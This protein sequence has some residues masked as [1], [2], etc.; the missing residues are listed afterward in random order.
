M[1]DGTFELCPQCAAPCPKHQGYPIWCEACGWSVEPLRPRPPASLVEAARARAGT[2]L[3]ASV[4][5]EVSGRRT[6]GIYRAATYLYA[7]LSYAILAAC[8]FGGIALIVLTWVNVFLIVIGVVLIGIAWVAR[9]RP[10][11]APRLVDRSAFAEVHALAD[12]VAEA[13][14]A[15]RVDGIAI[16]G[17]F[18]ASFGRYGWRGRRI[19]T[20]GLPLLTA[21]DPQERVALVAHEIAHDVNRD[22]ARTLFVANAFNVL[23]ELHDFFL[24]QQ[25]GMGLAY[26]RV[27]TRSTAMV[28]VGGRIANIVLGAVGL[29]IRPFLRLFALLMQRDSQRAEYLAD[30]LAA[31]VAGDASARTMLR[32]SHLARTFD[33]LAKG[34]AAQ[35][36]HADILAALRRWVAD[37]PDSEWRRVERIMQLE[38]TQI[39]STHP[40]S[41]QRI[42]FLAGRAPT[43]PRVTMT[44]DQR[45]AIDRELMPLE[46]AYTVSYLDEA[47]ARLYRR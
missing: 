44:A 40:P 5:G 4:L 1:T 19:M 24:P 11:K 35:G 45:D 25:L 2:W 7:L 37:A 18:N 6:F 23:A 34:A 12:R 9:P 21:L 36:E 47:R 30:A 31:D 16:N 28:T 43:Q 32:K 38:Q 10:A 3:A 46:R 13:L 20:L 27:L 14:G 29:A 22:P 41:S 17:E 26:G 8:L 15:H 42:A 33:N 39:D